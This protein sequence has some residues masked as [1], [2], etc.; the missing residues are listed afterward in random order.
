MPYPELMVAPMRRELTSLGFTE[1]KTPAEVDAFMDQNRD[2][3]VLL[4][5]NS[6]CGCAAGN[7]RPGVAFALRN[8]ARPEMLATVFAGQDLEAT[9]RAREYITGYP[10]SSPSITLFKGGEVVFMLERHQI[11]GRRPEEIAAALARAFDEH[12]AVA[13]EG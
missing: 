6:I 7:M 12:C 5:V 2:R 11:Q 3:T 13:A 8:A 10:P 4:A 9:E 1:L